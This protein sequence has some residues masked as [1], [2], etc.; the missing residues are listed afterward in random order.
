M[1]IQKGPPSMKLDGGLFFCV[2]VYLWLV[3][4]I[5]EKGLSQ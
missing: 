5:R 2:C 4:V 3:P 1:E